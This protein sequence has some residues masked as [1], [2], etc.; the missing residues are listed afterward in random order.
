MGG[1]GPLLEP[2]DVVSRAAKVAKP[3]KSS[4]PAKLYIHETLLERLAQDLEPM[5]ATLRQFVQAD[6]AVVRQRHLARHRHLAPADPPDVRDGV[7]RG[8]EQAGG[9]QCRAVAREAG[10]AMDARRLDGFGQ[11]H[12]RQDGG[13][14]PGQHGRAGPR[15]AEQEDVVRRTPASRSASPELLWLPGANTG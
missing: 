9:D 11:G 14:S 13:E 12:R 7:M 3:L 8:A 2:H 1:Y 4:T 6:D 10:D 15:G 5:A